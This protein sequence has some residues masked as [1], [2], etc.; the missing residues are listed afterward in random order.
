MVIDVKNSD[1]T[2]CRHDAFGRLVKVLLPGDSSW[3]HP[4]QRFDYYGGDDVN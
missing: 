3:T 4:S 1:T 2:S